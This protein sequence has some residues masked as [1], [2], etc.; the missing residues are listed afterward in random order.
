MITA[1][2]TE[3]LVYKTRNA[4]L[5]QSDSTNSYILRFFND[6][7]EFRACEFIS[8]KRKIQQLDLPQ[9]LSTEAPDVEVLYLPHC[10]RLMVLSIHEILELREVL[11]G[12]FTMLELN[13]VIHREIVRKV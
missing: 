2:S 5:S 1:T 10:D 8:F 4:S 11:A 12:A 3:H 13:S 9:L 6:E 7:L